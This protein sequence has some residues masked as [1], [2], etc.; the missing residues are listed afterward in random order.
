MTVQ[1]ERLTLSALTAPSGNLLSK[2]QPVLRVATLTLVTPIAKQLSLEGHPMDDPK[3]VLAQLPPCLPKHPVKMKELRTQWD[4]NCAR[5]LQDAHLTADQKLKVA[6]DWLAKPGL[7]DFVLGKLVLSFVR[8]LPI[9]PTE[10]Q[11]KERRQKT[12]IRLAYHDD[13]PHLRAVNTVVTK[14][15]EMAPG[16]TLQSL[17]VLDSRDDREKEQPG[18]MFAEFASSIEE[19][20]ALEYSSV[21]PD[22]PFADAAE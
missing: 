21:K 13:L 7:R 16:D 18:T 2:D 17:A 11:R 22:G 19:R 8:P 14:R 20:A 12:L 10:D 5:I 4:Q 6:M 15:L 9:P 1:T 3:T